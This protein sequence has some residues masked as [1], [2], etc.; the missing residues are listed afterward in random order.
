VFGFWDKLQSLLA[1][2]SGHFLTGLKLA[3]S[4]IV[5]RV[6][7]SLGLSFVLYSSALPAVK[8][9]LQGYF[10]AL[11]PQVLQLA[12]A[13]GIDI[14]MILILSAYVTKIGTRVFLAGTEALQNLVNNAQN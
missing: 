3:A 13:M 4:F 2:F 7:A 1:G 10:S 14:F 5:A 8:D 6:L 9:F 11:P 12:G